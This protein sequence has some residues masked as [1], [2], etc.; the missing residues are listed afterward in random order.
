L[1]NSPIVWNDSN[2]I[3]G[4]EIVIKTYDGVIQNMRINEEAFIVSEEETELYNQVKGKTLHAF[5]KDNE[6]YRID[7]NRS[8]QTIYYVRDEQDE[9]MGM[10][11]LDCSNMSIF[12]DSA[13]IN[14]IKF[15]KQPDGTFFPMKE[16]TV[17]MKLLRHF[18]WRIEERP[19]TIEDIFNWTDVPDRVVNR[20]RSK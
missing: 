20:R 13:G 5:F 2:Q 7:V 15:Y 19:L 8:G 14:N 4:K 11:R 1:Y 9:L 6:I 17:E 3:T 18:Y 12:V 16:I 10:N